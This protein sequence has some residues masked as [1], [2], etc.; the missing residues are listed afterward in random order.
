[1]RR[2]VLL[3]AIVFAAPVFADL[4]PA[5]KGKV[6]FKPADDHAPVAERYPL[7]PLEFESEL[8]PKRD[9]V[10]RENEIYDLTC[11]SPVHTKY[12]ENNTVHAEYYLPK[13]KGPFPGVIILDIM[14]GSQVVSR[15]IAALLATSGIAGL[16]V[17]MPY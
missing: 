10:V 9:R 1:M 12:S 6:A 7:D 4:K 2:T 15:S 16:C 13:G 5:E 11:P 3:A 17:Q 14:D 8:K